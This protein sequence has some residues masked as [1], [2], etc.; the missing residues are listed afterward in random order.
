MIR[1]TLLDVE[2]FC[3][4]VADRFGLKVQELYSRLATRFFSSRT[5]EAFFS[6]NRTVRS[7]MFLG[8]LVGFVMRAED[9]CELCIFVTCRDDY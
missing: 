6:W 3:F 8:G 2:R 7:Q 4:R 9:P 1:D 5:F